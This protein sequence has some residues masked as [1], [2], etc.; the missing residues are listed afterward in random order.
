METG[1]RSGG[2]FYGWVIVLAGC[3]I[4]AVVMGVV[5]NCF[6]QFIKPVCADLGFS[7]QAMSFNQTLISL[8]QVAVGFVWGKVL[9]KV[10]VKPLMLFWAV[11]GPAAFFCYSFADSIWLFY[12][13]S[14][15]MSLT[16]CMLTLLPLSYMISNWFIEKKGLA[17]GICYMGSGLGGMVLNP[18]LRVWLEQYGWRA[19]FRILAVIM[20]VFSIP[21]VLLMVESPHHKGLKPLGADRTAAAGPVQSGEESGVTLRE[22]RGTMR[23]WV[24]SVCVLLISAACSSLVQTL[25]PHL[26]D[27][28]Y[29]AA[30]AAN[31]V[32]VSMGAMAAGKMLLGWLYDVLGSKRASLL[33]V[34]CGLLGLLGMVFCRISPALGLIILGVGLG[35]AFGTVG[36]PIM[37][38]TVFGKRDFSAIVGI[39]VAFSNIGGALSPT[40]NGTVFDMAGSY[41]PA[42]VGWVA[43]MALVFLCFVSFLPGGRKQADKR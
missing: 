18:L 43:A 2:L 19:S 7:R 1:K 28:G 5:Y 39:F 15:I 36:P 33:S 13:I 16:M 25:S 37:V 42:Y 10:R 31:M 38:Q 6:S 35:C 20:A 22:A 24:L 41:T 40:V 27:R 14:A 12:V 21:C 3:L 9:S 11:V 26:T 23:F 32:S 30:F 8:I 34:L 29:S 17:T 4:M